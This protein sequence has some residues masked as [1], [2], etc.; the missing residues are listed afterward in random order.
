MELG[1][2]IHLL[3]LTGSVSTLYSSSLNDFPTG[4]QALQDR[5]DFIYFM[6]LEKKL[7]LQLVSRGLQGEA[8]MRG[9][10]GVRGSTHVRWALRRGWRALE[11]TERTD[12]ACGVQRPNVSF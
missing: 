3:T 2:R 12:T 8:G 6:L 11:L 1:D 7:L 5:N 9:E 4:F 10:S